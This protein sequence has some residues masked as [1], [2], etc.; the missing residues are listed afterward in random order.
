MSNTENDHG[1]GLG[2]NQPR[3]LAPANI[4]PSP[5]SHVRW[6]ILALIFV[7]ATLNYVDRLVIGILAPDLQKVFAISDIQYGYIQSAFAFSYAFGQLLAGG[8]LERLGTRLTYAVSLVSWSVTSM[9]HAA[10]MGPWSFGF[11]RAMLGACESPCFPAAA[12]TVAEWF[13]VRE[14]AFAYGFVNAGTNMGAILAPAVVPWLA[15]RY[16]WQW[17]FIATGGVGVIWVFFWWP[18]YRRPL[19]HPWVSPAEAAHITSDPPE[20]AAKQPWIKLVRFPQAWAFAAGKFFTDCLWWFYMTW[21]PK[22]LFDRHHLDLAHIGLPLVVVYLM[23]DAGSVAGGWISSTMIKRGATVNRARKTAMILC[24]A[25]VLPIM[26]AQWVSGLWTAVLILG[27]ATAGQQGF[28][29]NLYTLVGDMF[30]RNAIGSIAGFGGMTGFFGASLFQVFVGHMV[31]HY[32]S[33]SAPFLCAAVAYPVAILS[34]HLLAPELK[35]V[36]VAESNQV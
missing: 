19:E 8:V 34:I 17:A 20:T 36:N 28:S 4:Q 11:M 21:L 31:G 24:A 35:P 1:I 22:F 18:F 26:F 7:A 30:P 29:T 27:L 23:S 2:T 5:M 14:R 13:P 33:Y 10:A 16:G 32:Q 25:I 3:A 9:L 6:L 12:K 15:T